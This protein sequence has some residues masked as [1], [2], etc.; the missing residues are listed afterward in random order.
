M[1]QTLQIP[2]F[3]A[4]ST[5]EKSA[6]DADVGIGDSSIVLTYSDNIAPDDYLVIGRLGGESTELV[7]VQVVNNSVNVD[8]VGQTVKEHSRFDDVNLLFGNQI[9]I[10]RAANVDGTIPADGAFNVVGSAFDMDIDQTETLLT[11]PD[12]S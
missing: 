12:G 11:D 9:K 10:Y 1:S 8:I 4:L 6:L 5:R 2:N 3:T 7:Q